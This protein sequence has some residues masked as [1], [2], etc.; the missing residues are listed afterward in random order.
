MSYAKTLQSMFVKHYDGKSNYLVNFQSAV[1]SYL[2]DQGFTTQSELVMND[3]V[4]RLK[5]KMLDDLDAE[6]YPAISALMRDR[7]S[8]DFIFDINIYN[9]VALKCQIK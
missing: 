9:S 3:D 8:D 2:A 4:L 1:I 6:L 5:N 7:V